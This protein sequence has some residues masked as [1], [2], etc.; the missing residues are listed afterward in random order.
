VCRFA[1]LK[2]LK[3]IAKYLPAEDFKLEPAIYEMVL[4]DFLKT[5]P[6]GKDFFY[7][8]TSIPDMVLSKNR[9][10]GR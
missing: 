3:T 8:T 5:D 10:T 4:F 9:N 1:Q 7:C 2:Q 6:D